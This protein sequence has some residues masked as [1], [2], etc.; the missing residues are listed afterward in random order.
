MLSSIGT[1][2]AIATIQVHLNRKEF[3]PVNKVS[4]PTTDCRS[5]RQTYCHESYCTRFVQKRQISLTAK[6]K[7]EPFGLPEN[8]KRR[9]ELGGKCFDVLITLAWATRLG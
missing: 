3:D 7:E 1:R 2:D 9:G 8:T 6:G 4:V 5:L